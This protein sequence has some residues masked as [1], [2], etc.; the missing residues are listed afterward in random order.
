LGEEEPTPEG[1][2]SSLRET[3]WKAGSRDLVETPPGGP[4]M[5]D[6]SRDFPIPASKD[7]APGPLDLLVV[8]ENNTNYVTDAVVLRVLVSLAAATLEQHRSP[9]LRSIWMQS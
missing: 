3:K 6:K 1:Q 2:N 8:P 5:S 4:D 9:L 7:G